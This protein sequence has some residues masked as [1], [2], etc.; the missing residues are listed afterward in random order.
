MARVLHH[1]VYV[2]LLS[3]SAADKGKPHVYVGMT[4]LTPEERFKNHMS[5]EHSARIVHRRGLRLMPELYEHLPPMSYIDAAKREIQTAT[6]LR[7]A[8][9]IVTMFPAVRNPLL[10]L[11]GNK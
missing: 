7:K 1:H 10:D 8:G 6:D 9:Y 3:E 5:G 4:G 11:D 2:I